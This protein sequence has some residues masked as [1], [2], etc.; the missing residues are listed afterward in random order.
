MLKE[1][2]KQICSFTIKEGGKL[3]QERAAELMI[4]IAEKYSKGLIKNDQ[5]YPERDRV[6]D[7]ES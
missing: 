7:L 5:L 2:G 1:G 6:R 3:T 4:E